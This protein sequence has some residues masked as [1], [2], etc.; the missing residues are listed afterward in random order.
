MAGISVGVSSA[1]MSHIDSFKHQQV[2]EFLG[3]PVYLPLQD[4]DGDFQA[5]TR[6]LLVGGGSGEH[7][8][9]VLTDPQAAA[10]AF[11]AEEDPHVDLSAEELKAWRAAIQPFA[12]DF[13]HK[14]LAFHDWSISDYHGFHE[15]CRNPH[16]SS[17]GIHESKMGVEYWM[18]L[19]LGEFVF[20]AMPQ[21]APDLM[22]RLAAPYAKFRHVIYSEVLLVPP[23][24]PV[25][26]NG[27]NAFFPRK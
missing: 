17:Y 27:G 13:P 9:V 23:N 3:L 7:P 22:A 20:Y 26:A 25:Y 2:G 1:A 6:Q 8:A 24:M 15:R 10:A 16:T 19:G 14:L 18:A 5:T 12:P 4:I 21:L 11:L